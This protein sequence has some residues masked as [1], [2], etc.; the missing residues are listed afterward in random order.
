MYPFLELVSKRMVKYI[1]DET[2]QT[3]PLEARELCVKY[4]LDNIALCAFGVDGKCFDEPLSE[5][6]DLAE[7]FLSP[8][9]LILKLK[10][11]LMFNLPAVTDYI[12]I[13]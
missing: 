10:F 2:K 3:G 7:K 6:R 12:S 8:S 9:N 11:W 1:E 5:F 13:S 4:T